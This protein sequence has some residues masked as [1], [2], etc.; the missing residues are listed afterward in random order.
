MR[1]NEIIFETRKLGG[2]PVKVVHIQDQAVDEGDVVNPNF[3][4]RSPYYK[5]PDIDIP[6]Y[7]PVLRRAWHD[8]VSGDNPQEPFDEFEIEPAGRNSAH[9]IGVK[10]GRRVKI[11]TAHERLARALVGAYNRGGFT[12]VPLQK[13]S[14][15]PSKPA[16]PARG[17]HL[18][19]VK[20]AL[21]LDAP[22]QRMSRDELHGYVDRIK[23]GTKTKDRKSTRLNSSHTDISRMPSSA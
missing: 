16:K 2:F 22:Q 5:N 13:V 14:F 10:G 19:L 12:D 15:E 3:G 20:E 1:Y 6:Q 9:I 8:A 21:K 17:S 7:D 4:A 23:S 18:S 11:S